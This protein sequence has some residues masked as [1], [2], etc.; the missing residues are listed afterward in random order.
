MTMVKMQKL[1]E[2]ASA[3]FRLANQLPASGLKIVPGL[4]TTS[5]AKERAK[6]PV[7]YR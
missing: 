1:Q 5:L 2:R 7:D 6:S 4:R 3:G